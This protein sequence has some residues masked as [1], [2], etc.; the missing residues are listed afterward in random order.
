MEM[1]K[2]MEKEFGEMDGSTILNLTTMK[3]DDSL[4]KKWEYTSNFTS[5]LVIRLRLSDFKY[6]IFTMIF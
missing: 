5:P 6:G 4:L 1:E 2:K 3:I